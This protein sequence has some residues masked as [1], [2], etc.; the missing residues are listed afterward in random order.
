MKIVCIPASMLA[1]IL[2]IPSLGHGF[3]GP[4]IETLKTGSLEEQV[5]AMYFFGYSGNRKAFWHLVK[6]LD[7]SFDKEDKNQWGPVFR[8]AA[9]ISLGRL[10]DDR[11]VPFLVKRY[12]VETNEKVKQ[13]VLFAL[14]FYRN[15]DIFPVIQKGLAATDLETK[16]EA[17]RC[18][19]RS[20]TVAASGDIKAMTDQAD[21]FGL[22]M[23]GS[24][25]L[26]ALGTEPDTYSRVLVE[27]LRHREP[28][29]RFWAAWYI[30]QVELTGAIDE[31][32]RALEIENYSWV[33]Q[34]M[35]R[36]LTVLY[37]ARWR[38][39]KDL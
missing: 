13:A 8:Q 10:Q 25:A 27:G 22:R 18:A 39:E 23:A 26:V 37:D 7:R 28:E 19:A 16:I 35:E 21:V 17:L 38:R 12:E 6:N 24:Y 31:I 15:A 9:A 3:P 14:G 36:A 11:G 29:I 4:T 33:R 1:L 2:I 34:E 30:S 5:E 20:G 32:I